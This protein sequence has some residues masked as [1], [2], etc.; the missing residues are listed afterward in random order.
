MA[1]RQWLGALTRPERLA[2]SLTIQYLPTGCIVAAALLPSRESLDM[3][4]PLALA[5]QVL[6]GAPQF[7]PHIYSVRVQASALRLWDPAT[8]QAVVV[9]PYAVALDG[10]LNRNDSARVPLTFEAQP[11]D[12][13]RDRQDTTLTFTRASTHTED[14]LVAPM[15]ASRLRLSLRLDAGKGGTDGRWADSVVA[16]QPDSVML[17][18]VI[19]GPMHGTPRAF[20]KIALLPRLVAER[21]ETLEVAV[22]AWSTSDHPDARASLRVLR[23]E[24]VEQVPEQ[25]VSIA[26]DQPLRM[27]LNTITKQIDPTRLLGAQ[28]LYRYE[29]HAPD[30]TVLAARERLLGFMD[31]TGEQ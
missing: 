6:A 13:K 22:Q 7:Q 21:G 12:G 10:H 31:S 19:I 25:V 4:V 3:I 17:S 23:I 14:F 26:F 9:V 18:D 2:P 20:D 29:V 1:R 27:G 16:I 30:G 11:T 5:L 28:Y 8:R 15:L 24:G